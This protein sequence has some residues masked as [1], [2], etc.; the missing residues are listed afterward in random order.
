MSPSDV[1][2]QGWIKLHRKLL[3]NPIVQRSQYWHLWTFLLLRASHNESGFI[4][5]GKRVSL[6]AGQLLTGRTHL[7]QDTGISESTIERILSY[8]ES[9]HQIEQQKT[10]KFR[11]ITIKN[12]EKYQSQ[13]DREQQADNKRT[14]DGQQADTFKNKEECIRMKK[15]KGDPRPLQIFEHWNFLKGR[16]IRK[17]NKELEEKV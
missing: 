16:T 6:H 8:L 1:N 9:E 14:T 11:I 13:Y 4:W 10:N 5:N 15:K 3:E 12:W 17:R 7:S 2:N